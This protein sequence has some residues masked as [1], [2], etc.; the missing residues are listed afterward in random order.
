MCLCFWFL[1]FVWVATL[2]YPTNV[3]ESPTGWFN[4]LWVHEWNF[5][6]QSSPA[7]GARSE[8]C[9]QT[10][11]SA[12]VLLFF[13]TTSWCNCSTHQHVD[14]HFFSDRTS[15]RVSSTPLDSTPVCA[16]LF[17]MTGDDVSW[18]ISSSDNESLRS[19]G[20]VA[21]LGGA[22]DLLPTPPVYIFTE[23]AKKKIIERIVHFLENVTLRVIDKSLDL[24]LKGF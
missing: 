5:W 18:C 13:A 22:R 4:L 8:R 15:A 16:I 21:D 9:G 19:P 1:F 3:S 23:F 12:W 6:S 14:V 10:S 20:A 7:I 17:R 24:C 11:K 2:I